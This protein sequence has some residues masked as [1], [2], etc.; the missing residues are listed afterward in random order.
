MF[1]IYLTKRA[2]RELRHLLPDIR[3]RIEEKVEEL[4]SNP[5]PR[6]VAS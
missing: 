1:R 3:K 2:D 5:L 6:G 4:S